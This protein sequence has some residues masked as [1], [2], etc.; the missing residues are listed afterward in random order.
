[1]VSGSYL[2]LMK[3]GDVDYNAV[4]AQVGRLDTPFRTKAV[5][6]ARSV[7]EAHGPLANDGQFNAVI[8]KFLSKHH[9]DL[10]LRLG[11]ESPTKAGGAL[12]HKA[13]GTRFHGITSR[14]G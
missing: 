1:M 3:I 5:S 12:W 10:G 9:D 14:Y 7:C 11:K 8:G 2:A 13:T 4:K 6:K